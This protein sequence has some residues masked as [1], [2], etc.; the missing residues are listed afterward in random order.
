MTTRAR[1][2]QGTIK[3]AVDRIKFAIRFAGT[4]LSTLRPGDWTNLI[5]D[6]CQFLSIT[7]GIRRD[8]DTSRKKGDPASLLH[9]VK[10]W[11]TQY[12]QEGFVFGD[13]SVLAS[14]N[15]PPFPWDYKAAEFDNLQ[16]ELKHALEG[17]T[18][19]Y[20]FRPSEF[21]RVTLSLIRPA[22]LSVSGSTR[23]VFF[24]TLLFLLFKEGAANIAKC[25]ECSEVFWRETRRQ[26]F[27]S[28][29]CAN[30]ASVKAFHT[31]RRQQQS[32]QK[33]GKTQKEKRR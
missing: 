25:P 15:K 30:L 6:L 13:G 12:D 21:S 29:R 7:Q 32:K 22:H 28:R 1:Q 19:G 8:V 20:L 16:R 9:P 11:V 3:T 23:D 18:A 17:G 2:R 26:K 10:G 14:P 31:R 24:V 5:D 27:C 33:S 4:D